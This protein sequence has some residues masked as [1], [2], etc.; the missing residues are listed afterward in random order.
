MRRYLK[1]LPEQFG[2]IYGKRVFKKD[3]KQKNFI[4][5]FSVLKKKH[6][7]PVSVLIFK[8]PTKVYI[9]LD[10]CNFRDLWHYW[11]GLHWWILQC[12]TQEKT[13]GFVSE[14]SSFNHDAKTESLAEISY[15]DLY[16]NKSRW[17]RFIWKILYLQQALRNCT[18]SFNVFMLCSLNFFFLF[19]L[20]VC[21]M[22]STRVLVF[23]DTC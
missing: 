11:S 15:Q 13:V 7:E 23:L 5:H 3:L 8:T 14:Y 10:K 19:F 6:Y 2:D 17:D 21:I 22:A 9:L 12:K 20:L 18:K 16:G 1:Y 4:F